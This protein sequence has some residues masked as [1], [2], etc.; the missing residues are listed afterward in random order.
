MKP[1]H[2]FTKP[3]EERPQ[4]QLREGQMVYGRLTNMSKTGKI[5]VSIGQT[6]MSMRVEGQVA[7][8]EGAWFEVARDEDGLFLRL[9]NWTGASSNGNR[10]DF[11][12]LIESWQLP[13]TAFTQQFL[14]LVKQ[15]GAP[16]DRQTAQE[17][18]QLAKQNEGAAKL[19]LQWMIRSNTGTTVE[20]F[21]VLTAFFANKP[22]VSQQMAE[23]TTLLT[24]LDKPIQNRA[25]HASFLQSLQTPIPQKIVRSLLT[26]LVTSL[27]QVE[28]ASGAQMSVPTTQ[29]WSALLHVTDGKQGQQTVLSR[30]QAVQHYGQRVQSGIRSSSLF[31][32]S[33]ATDW[34]LAMERMDRGQTTQSIQT[35]Q[36][37]MDTPPQTKQSLVEQG[38]QVLL[39]QIDSHPNREALTEAFVRLLF[40]STTAAGPRIQQWSDQFI[41]TG[42]MRLSHSEE[43]LSMKEFFTNQIKQELTGRIQQMGYDIET[44]FAKSDTRGELATVKALLYQLISDL[45]KSDQEPFQQ[46]LNTLHAQKLLAHEAGPLLQFFTAFP[47]PFHEALHDV[48]MYWQGKKTEDDTID[49]DHCRLWFHLHLEQLQ[50]V[51]V[52]V[53]IQ[54]KVLNITVFHDEARLSSIAAPY[55]D[56]LQ[57]GIEKAGFYFSGVRFQGITEKTTDTWDERFFGV[58]DLQLDVKI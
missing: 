8:Q 34:Y 44:Q 17:I 41:K 54:K 21:R 22:V 13:N 31:Q 5:T 57:K 46:Q 12:R 15:M 52:D 14:Q 39:Q 45:T 28:T 37:W 7:L 2:F 50:E 25:G 23:L 56:A 19:A 43:A 18:T 38:I 24:H 42:E 29:A 30:E 51:V 36:K 3:Q 11:S 6:Q 35:M 40:P 58:E 26:S 10:V 1:V 32:L 16:L 53:R 33:F 27:F 20:P 47:F 9:A 48:E 55:I 4:P 49:P